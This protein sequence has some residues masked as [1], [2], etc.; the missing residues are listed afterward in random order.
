M[1]GACVTEVEVDVLTGELNI[2]RSDI[3]EDTGMAISPEVDVGQVE[4]GYV[5]GLGMWT[6][7][8]AK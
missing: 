7:E 3:V 6:T 1:W 5:M 2:V 4:G 8:R